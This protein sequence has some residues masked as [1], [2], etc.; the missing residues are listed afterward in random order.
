[1]REAAR[2]WLDSARA[3]VAVTDD[4][5]QF[6]ER[7]PNTGSAAVHERRALRRIAT[8]ATPLANVD[9]NARRLRTPFS[10]TEW[11][12]RAS[13]GE[14]GSPSPRN[15]GY[16]LGQQKRPVE[17]LLAKRIRVN[18]KVRT[19][20]EEDGGLQLPRAHVS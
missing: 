5:A 10:D 9:A 16:A 8:Q 7:G 19:T 15:V 4:F 6:E 14:D 20:R 12:K 2:W 17:F 13:V 18:P 3:C 1:V 11:P